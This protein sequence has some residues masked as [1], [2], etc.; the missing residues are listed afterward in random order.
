MTTTTN[1][2]NL[3]YKSR[4]SLIAEQTLAFFLNTNL[5]RKVKKNDLKWPATTY[6]EQ[7]T[8]WNNLQGTRNDLK[9]YT[10]SSKRSE[11]THNEYNTTYNNLNLPTMSK[12]RL[13]NN[14]QQR[15]FEII[16]QYGMTGSLL[17]HVFHPTFDC[18]HSS[19]ASES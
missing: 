12:I 9:W 3:Q 18:N 13:T 8:T 19:T 6:N 5:V 16:L 2:E 17:Y 4:F 7:E 15:D 1:A 14:Q 11:M 10:T